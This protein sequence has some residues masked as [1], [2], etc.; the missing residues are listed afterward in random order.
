MNPRVTIG[1]LAVLAV[2][3]VAVYFSEF[4]RE[5]PPPGPAAKEKDDP[6]LV[7]WTFDD[8][9]VARVEVVKDEN[10]TTVER[11]VEEWVLQPS[12]EPAERFRIN[13]L[14]SRLATLKGTKRV[15]DPGLDL[16]P[17]GLVRPQMATRLTMKDLTVFELL[18]GA[19]TPAEAGTYVMKPGDPTVFVIANTIVSDLERMV[20]EPPKAPPIP[21][22]FPTI[23][24]TPESTGG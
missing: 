6:Q 9:D 8:R 10:T 18:V 21:T 11:E 23:T 24:P 2:L 7:V 14:L 19:K 5:A 4:R 22:P 1:F 3:G 20:T 13:S 15:D 17:F 12:G 16:G